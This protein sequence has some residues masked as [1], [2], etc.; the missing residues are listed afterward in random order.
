MHYLLVIVVI[1]VILAYQFRSFLRNQIKRQELRNI[2]PEDPYTALSTSDKTPESVQIDFVGG[3]A[4]NETF[5]GIINSINN[6]LGKNKGATDFHILKDITDR[7]CDTLE[8]EID[9]ATPIPLYL[10]LSGTM[11]GVIIGVFFIWL[12]GGLSELLASPDAQAIQGGVAG[13]AAGAKGIEGLLGGVALAMIASACG[14]GFTIFGT[15]SSQNARKENE[16]KKNLFL[17]WVQGEL[18]P[19][20]SSNMGNTL[21]ILQQNLTRFNNDFETNS[22]NLNRVL[23]EINTTYR[24]QNDFL[25]TIEE[26]KIKDIASANIKVLR[27]LQGCTDRISDLNLFLAESGKYLTSIETLNGNL[28]DSYNRTLLIE[29]MGE[30]F[31]N[32]IKQVE[33][34]KTFIAQAVGIVDSTMQKAIGELSEH[35][36]NQIGELKKVTAQEHSAFIKA[37][38]EQQESLSHKITETSQIIAEVQNLAAVKESMGQ[39]VSASDLQNEKM[40]RLIQAFSEYAKEAENQPGGSFDSEASGRGNTPVI[41][42]PQVPG[43]VIYTTCFVIVGSCVFMIVKSFL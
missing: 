20:M 33:Q 23:G 17:T 37:V 6:Y 25:K 21:E 43:W 26:L 9:A 30:F 35:T 15:S 38:E 10:G 13:A 3:K 27:E 14:I 19:Q 12:G 32:E 36:S 2:F 18:L 39:L 5:N 40:D 7:N 28:S 34:R 1:I 42:E 16:R 22:N 41:I 4:G 31:M 24:E 11:L 29:K 8:Q